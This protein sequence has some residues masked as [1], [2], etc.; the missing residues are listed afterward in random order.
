LWEGMKPVTFG[1][2]FGLAGAL[3]LSR[4]L[5]TLLYG[6]QAH[7]LETFSTAVALLIAVCLVANLIPATRAT[8]VDPVIALRQ[9]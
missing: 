1:I 2:A 5:A 7:D 8:R 3:F 9:S 6:V 4:F